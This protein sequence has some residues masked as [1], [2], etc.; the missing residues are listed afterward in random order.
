MSAVDPPGSTFYDR[1]RRRLSPIDLEQGDEEAVEQGCRE[2]EQQ[3]NPQSPYRHE[4]ET[5][6]ERHEGRLDL[7]QRLS[8]PEIGNLKLENEIRDH[9]GEDVVA[10]V[11]SRSGSSLRCSLASRLADMSSSAI[12][13]YGVIPAMPRCCEGPPTT[14]TKARD[15]RQ[16]SQD[17]SA[18]SFGW[19]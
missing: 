2:V 4:Q 8:L 17:L 18:R 11:S 9:G 19:C 10:E 16:G 15:R 13:S 5:D 12:A 6:D 7:G 14:S 3:P 1:L